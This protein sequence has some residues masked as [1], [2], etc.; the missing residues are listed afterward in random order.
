MLGILHLRIYVLNTNTLQ[1]Y[2]WYT[3]LVY[4]KSAKLEQLILY[5]MHFNCEYCTSKCIAEVQLKIY[6]SILDC[7]KVELLQVHFR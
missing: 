2:F 4:L 6:W 7:A 5:L 3:K 1:V